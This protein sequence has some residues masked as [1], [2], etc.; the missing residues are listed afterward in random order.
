[1]S[2]CLG[3]RKT[4][5]K[6]A[7]STPKGTQIKGKIKVQDFKDKVNILKHKRFPVKRLNKRN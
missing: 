3:K 7:V 6:W 1:M 5:I 2:V 4:N